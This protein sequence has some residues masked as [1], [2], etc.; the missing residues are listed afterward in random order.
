MHNPVS[1][2]SIFEFPHCNQQARPWQAK[3]PLLLLRSN[4]PG[5]HSRKVVVDVI[6]L[7]ALR[8]LQ[9]EASSVSIHFNFNP[10]RHAKTRAKTYRRIHTL[11]QLSF[12]TRAA[13]CARSRRRPAVY[14]VQELARYPIDLQCTATHPIQAFIHSRKT[15][16]TGTR[17]HTQHGCHYNIARVI[18]LL[19]RTAH[20][21]LGDRLEADGVQAG[22]GGA[23]GRHGGGCRGTSIE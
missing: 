4:N 21:E 6:R 16:K 15:Q 9:H 20:L 14:S 2:I 22:R 12:Q 7:L 1:N 19:V 10:S 11:S 23:L 17:Q 3:L 8:S 5:I 18:L 13:L